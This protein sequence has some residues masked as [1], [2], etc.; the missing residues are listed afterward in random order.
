MNSAE[1]IEVLC[2]RTPQHGCRTATVPTFGYSNTDDVAVAAAVALKSDVV[3]VAVVGADRKSVR[4]VAAV[5]P[6]VVV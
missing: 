1:S 2:F 4:P 3:V 6:A 5:A